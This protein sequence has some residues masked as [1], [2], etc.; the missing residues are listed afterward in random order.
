MRFHTAL[1]TG[2]AT[3]TLASAAFAQRV[4]TPKVDIAGPP[5]P[6]PKGK[7][8]KPKHARAQCPKPPPPPL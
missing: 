5:A 1:L 6:K 4:P 3:A 8:R 2:L 7:K